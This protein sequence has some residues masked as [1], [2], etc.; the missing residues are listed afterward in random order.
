MWTVII[1]YIDLSCFLHVLEKRRSFDFS[2]QW[3]LHHRWDYP[4]FDS[5]L[6][7]HQAKVEKVLWRMFVVTYCVGMTSACGCSS[8]VCIVYAHYVWESTVRMC[9]CM[10]RVPRFSILHLEFYACPRS[11][12]LPLYPPTYMYVWCFVCL[13]WTAVLCPDEPHFLWKLVSPH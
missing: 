8:M 5:G 3:S 4:S 10:V 6:C 1:F 13:I 7:R 11:V 2:H 9:V 12:S